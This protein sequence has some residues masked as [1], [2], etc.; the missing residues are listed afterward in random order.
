MYAFTPCLEGTQLNIG[1][2][3]SLDGP[4]GSMPASTEALSR[5]SASAHKHAV[6]APL[7]VEIA[8]AAS[9]MVVPLQPEFP[10]P[11]SGAYL[12][13]LLRDFSRRIA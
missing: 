8:H 7:V 9:F 4:G 10:E 3:M 12:G 6:R 2:F 11:S 5:S 1:I 13:S